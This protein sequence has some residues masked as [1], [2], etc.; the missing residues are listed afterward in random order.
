MLGNYYWDYAVS[1]SVY[2][3]FHSREEVRLELDSSWTPPFY[4]GNRRIYRGENIKIS[5]SARAP[6]TYLSAYFARIFHIYYTSPPPIERWENRC[7]ARKSNFS[8]KK[9]AKLTLKMIDGFVYEK[10]VFNKLF[11]HINRYQS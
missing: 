4:N 1:K 11:S 2:I 7:Q 6:L 9:F 3:Y 8:F 10:I 5:Q